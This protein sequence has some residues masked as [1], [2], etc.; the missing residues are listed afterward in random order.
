TAARGA[1]SATRR[2]GRE[3]RAPDGGVERVAELTLECQPHASG[4]L[5]APE[6]SPANAVFGCRRFDHEGHQA[7]APTQ[8]VVF[9]AHDREIAES[10][11]VVAGKRGPRASAR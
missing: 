6:P 2:S 11:L 7:A 10:E 3:T 9:L 8:P 1:P 5:F 4:R